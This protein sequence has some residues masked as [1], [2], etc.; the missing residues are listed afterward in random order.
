MTSDVF[1]SYSKFDKATADAVCARLETDGLTCWIASR[2]ILPGVDWGEAIIDAI[3]ECKIMVL[4]FSGH[5]NTSIQIK[6]EVERGIN[7]N[8]VVIPF[9]IEDVPPSKTLEFFISTPH[10]LNAF[11]PPLDSHLDYLVRVVRKNLKIQVP[12]PPPP[13]PPPKEELPDLMNY[14]NKTQKALRGV[15]RE[16]LLQAAKTGFPGNHHA[17]ITFLT[18]KSGVVV[19]KDLIEK[20]PHDI[21]IV[22]QHHYSNLKVL[23][24]HFLVTLTFSGVPA[25][26]RVPYDA[27]IRYHDPEAQFMLEFEVDE[28]V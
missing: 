20:Y 15:I 1:I 6:R 16:S 7:H 28:T 13:P 17:Y 21:T 9:R 19:T 27:I 25:E 5:A 10:W 4:I 2:D 3:A 11:P 23:D 22:L 18:K 26:L 8:L 24:D 14:A 12:P